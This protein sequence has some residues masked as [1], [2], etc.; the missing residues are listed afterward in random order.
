MAR[1]SLSDDARRSTGAVV[2]A[3]SQGPGQ[4]PM[5]RIAVTGASGFLGRH[6][7]RGVVAPG[8]RYHR[9]RSHAPARAWDWRPA[10]LEALPTSRAAPGRRVRSSPP[11]GHR[12]SP[13]VGRIAE[14]PLAPARGGRAPGAGA[15]PAGARR[16][17][18]VQARDRRDL[19]RIRHAVGMPRRG[20]PPLPSNAYGFAKDGL[21]RA[22]AAPAGAT[23][24]DREMAAPV[25]SLRQRTGADV[26][27]LAIP[28][29]GRA[30][31]QDI[32]HVRG[33]S[34]ARFHES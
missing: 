31:R 33:R 4:A 26:A 13:R 16:G 15:L 9:A 2:P 34:D 3:A 30:R 11:P 27:L 22:L 20:T 25:L 18:V 5:T 32:R 17:R 8:P 7:L 12:H 1:R 23:P 28:H 14:L 21:R 19:L 10:P 6:V 29:G 24:F